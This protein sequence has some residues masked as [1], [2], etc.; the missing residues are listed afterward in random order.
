MITQGL[1]QQKR[2]NLRI[3]R[4]GYLEQKAI[5]LRNLLVPASMV[6]GSL[7]FGSRFSTIG[8]HEATDASEPRYLHVLL[9]MANTDWYV[10]AKLNRRMRSSNGPLIDSAHFI[11]CRVVHVFVYVESQIKRV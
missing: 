9:N 10:I 11:P 8:R 5:F 1:P 6:G 7:S 4:V 3:R 2:I